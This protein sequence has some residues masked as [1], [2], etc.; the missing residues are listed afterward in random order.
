MTSPLLSTTVLNWNRS[1]LLRSTI[2]SYLRTITVPYEL[3]IVDNAS[4]DDSPRMIEQ[5]C[6]DNSHHKAVLLDLNLGGTAINLGLDESCGRFLHVSGNDLEYR[7]GWDVDLIRKLEHFGE[8]GQLS[9]FSP[10][11][12]VDL[13]EIWTDKRALRDERDG[14]TV[15]LAL[16]NV[17]TSSVFRREV[18]DCGVR[19]RTHGTSTFSSPDDHA[20]SN[21][22]RSIG[23]EVAWNDRYVVRNLGHSAPEMARRLEYYLNN[24]SGK[25]YLGVSR[26]L[27]AFREHGFDVLILPD[28]KTRLTRTT[29][30]DQSPA[31]RRSRLWR[32]W[33]DRL[34]R[35][36]AAL[37]AAI[38]PGSSYVLVDDGSFEPRLLPQRQAYSLP[39]HNGEYWGPPNDDSEA[40]DE[41]RNRRLR[42][43]AYVVVLWPA[44]WWRDSYS[45]LFGYLETQTEMVSWTE[46]FQLYRF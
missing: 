16:D 15:Y 2:E 41:L 17:G 34:P 14:L 3:F 40:V 19:W 46:D 39:D 24:A 20:F 26:L 5:F 21:D 43:V 42:G 7:P 23:Y 6:R 1:D 35:A 37:E 12:E 25:L 38:P 4:T 11:H 30:V 8:L 18:W 29:P 9:L 10:F 22:V 33:L 28:G 36:R 27:A 45:G 31:M 44:F 13:D 32:K